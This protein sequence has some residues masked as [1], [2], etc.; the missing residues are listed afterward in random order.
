ME[1]SE[2]GTHEKEVEVS[3]AKT[4]IL[5][6]EGHSKYEEP[7]IVNHE[8]NRLI[9]L[10]SV[11][12]KRRNLRPALCPERII[13]PTCMIAKVAAKKDPFNHRRRWPMSSARLSGTSVCAIALQTYLSILQPFREQR[14]VSNVAQTYQFEF[15]FATISKHRMR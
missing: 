7:T 6:D 8:K 4:T 14:V 10:Y 12:I 1:Y 13:W 5:A 11:S 3:L 2:N 15:A 9:A